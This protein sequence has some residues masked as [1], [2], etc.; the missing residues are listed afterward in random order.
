MA[1]NWKPDYIDLDSEAWLA[2]RTR[3]KLGDPRLWGIYWEIIHQLN[4][5][6][7]WM[8]YD[9]DDLLA[10][11]LATPEELDRVLDIRHFLI[12]EVN[13]EKWLAHEVIL[14]KIEALRSR[15]GKRS[16]AGIRSGEVRRARSG[17][18]DGGGVRNDTGTPA[19]QRSNGVQ[20]MFPAPVPASDSLPPEPGTVF[21]RCSEHPGNGVQTV[22]KGLTTDR[23]TRVGAREA[24]EPPPRGGGAPPPGQI[25]PGAHRAQDQD[26]HP[27]R[28]MGVGPLAAGR[29]PNPA[30]ALFDGKCA[31]ARSRPN[32]PDDAQWP[33]LSEPWAVWYRGLQPGFERDMV[34][35]SFERINGFQPEHG[36]R[37]HD[38]A[39]PG[40]WPGTEHDPAPVAPGDDDGG[41]EATGT[42]GPEGAG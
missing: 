8:L 24:T 41:N 7:G 33:W 39:R 4:S 21:E 38:A 31:G 16:A 19:E 32:C 29:D 15:L 26:Q 14:R 37:A 20:Q 34:R 1:D 18:G 17:K 6:G 11:T 28:S 3:R 13:G 40:G 2:G 27:G 35:E 36:R 42:D 23:Q 12:R 10:S 22:S 9:H 5:A 25:K 30:R